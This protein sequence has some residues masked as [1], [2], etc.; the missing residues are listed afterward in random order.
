MLR[1][2]VHEYWEGEVSLAFQGELDGIMLPEH[3]HRLL[4][5]F[6]FTGCCCDLLLPA[7]VQDKRCRIIA[8][9]FSIKVR[10][11]H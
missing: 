9:Q 10:H 5:S 6:L 3:Y 8:R 4:D 1:V 7:S 11:L 2:E